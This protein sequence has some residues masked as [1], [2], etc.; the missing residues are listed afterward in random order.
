MIK[1]IFSLNM[2]RF[3]SYNL[4]LIISTVRLAL[5]DIKYEGATQSNSSFHALAGNKYMQTMYNVYWSVLV[6]VGH[7]VMWYVVSF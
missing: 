3:F 5:L 7:K 6:S 2:S 1:Q 4:F